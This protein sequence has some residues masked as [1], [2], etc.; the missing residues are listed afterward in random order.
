MP[1]YE[2]RYLSFV[3]SLVRA[4]LT[5]VIYVTSLPIM[6]RLLDYYLQLTPGLDDTVWSRLIPVS[7][8]DPSPRP[9][10]QKILERPLL[11]ERLRR[12]ITTPDHVVVLPFVTT[13]LEARLA[14]ELDAPIYGPNP[15][16][17]HL[18]TKTGSRSVFAAV[19]VPHA[20]GVEGL[21]TESDL[22]DAL[23]HIVATS[24]PDGAIV[25]LDDAVSGFGNALIDLTDARDRD[26]LRRRIRAMQP[27]N[28]AMSPGEF[29]DAL[30]VEAGVV[31]ERLTGHDFR[32]PSVQ[33][34]GSPEGLTEVLS[35]HDQILG[36][37]S[38]QTYFGCRFPAEPG[39]ASDLARHGTA[40]AEEL[41][42]HGVIGR[43]A[44]DF[45]AA[46][47]DHGWAL[48]AIEINLRNGG[49][50]HPA[51]TLLALT[52]GDYIADEGRFVVD[53]VDK[54]Y[55]ATDHLEAPGLD[56]LT[57]DDVLDLIDE[58]GLGWD[59]ESATGAVLHM[60]SAVG[61]A[62]RVG[63]TAIANSAVE[64]QNRFET[65]QQSLTNLAASSA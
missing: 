32:S 3:L 65:L 61:V 15:S 49:T 23:E 17:R 11:I 57:P 10:T 64:A 2:E 43:F 62:G 14:L 18:G 19:G 39:Y 20:A 42:R 59:A 54:H 60:V 46:R 37:K 22:L 45:V 7:M 1:S 24:Q 25:K 29:L 56:R 12:L 40:I 13:E 35:T 34:R 16:L 36:G 9:L 8:G 6:P 31:E 28:E 41:V 52:E 21:R 63:V 50:T 51:L 48:H 53:G 27:E 38:G 58:R 44:V 5:R 33:L 55:V 4:P 30:A 26:E 47:T